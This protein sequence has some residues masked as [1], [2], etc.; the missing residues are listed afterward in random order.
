MTSLALPAAGVVELPRLEQNFV[1]GLDHWER[2]LRRKPDPERKEATAVLELAPKGTPCPNGNVFQP[3]CKRRNCRVCGGRW[4]RDVY[5]VIRFNLEAF[6]KPVTVIAITPPGKE[7]LP[8]DRDRCRR[9][10][11]HGEHVDCEGG[12]GCRV[13]DRALREWSETLTWRAAK[14]RKAAYQAIRRSGL[15]GGPPRWLERTY[16]PQRRGAAHLHIVLPYGSFQEKRLARAYVQQLKR[17]APE[18]DF[19]NVDGKLKAWQGREA[20]RYL[21]SYLTGRNSKK[22]KSTMRANIADPNLPSSLFWVSP[23]LTRETLVTMRSLRRARHVWAA[24]RDPLVPMP[25][26]SGP[27]DAVKGAAAFW[28]VYHS[29]DSRAGPGEAA[30]VSALELARRIERDLR[31]LFLAGNWGAWYLQREEAR[32]FATRLADHLL[33]PVEAAAAC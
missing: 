4:G 22:G 3:S 14:L 1:D 21:A 13:Q 12:K 27:L 8:W 2:F 16:E 28:R 33:P 23:L 20:A 17:L 30:L 29:K 18:Y 10:K 5:T 31:E 24:R 11:L 9:L 7:R 19:G 25:K 26:W 15:T 6:G 32:E